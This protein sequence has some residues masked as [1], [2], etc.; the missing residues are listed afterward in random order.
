MKK[1]IITFKKISNDTRMSEIIHESFTYSYIQS[2]LHNVTEYADY[3]KLIHNIEM[4][5]DDS[6]FYLSEL[7]SSELSDCSE[8]DFINSLDVLNNYKDMKNKYSIEEYAKIIRIINGMDDY[9]ELWSNYEHDQMEGYYW[10]YEYIEDNNIP[11]ICK[12][13]IY[14]VVCTIEQEITKNKN[15]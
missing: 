1:Y 8:E 10:D 4:F 5:I 2:D 15:N 12:D 3:I 6:D 11:E 14:D 7:S 13:N 9:I